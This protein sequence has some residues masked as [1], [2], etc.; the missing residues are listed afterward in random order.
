[1]KEVSFFLEFE[2]HRYLTLDLSWFKSR[3]LQQN[4]HHYSTPPIKSVTNARAKQG[5]SRNRNNYILTG[6]YQREP[7]NCRLCHSAP[8]TT[9]NRC[10]FNRN[11][12]PLTGINLSDGSGQVFS[13][14]EEARRLQVNRGPRLRA[15]LAIST[16]WPFLFLRALETADGSRR[17][18]PPRRPRRRQLS[19]R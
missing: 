3:T 5:A 12:N 4:E 7:E 2:R 14:K 13:E 17:S 6:K 9:G 16:A 11:A 15:V 10:S 19:A 18:N 8:P 1:M